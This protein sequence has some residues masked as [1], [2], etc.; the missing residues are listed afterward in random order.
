MS[1]WPH[2]TELAAKNVEAAEPRR[3]E[4]LLRVAARHHVLLG[5]EGRHVEIVDHVLGGHQETHRA[6]H[7]HVE[8]VQLA[9]ALGVLDVPHP[10]LADDVDLQR[11][12]VGRWDFQPVIEG[13]APDE[14]T[15]RDHQ[16]DGAPYEFDFPGLE[17][18]RRAVGVA[19]LTVLVQE[20]KHR[21][22]DHRQ[23]DQRE[24]DQRVE[25]RVRLPRHGGGTFGGKREVHGN[26]HKGRGKIRRGLRAGGG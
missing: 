10:L 25:K 2:A 6:T 13:R 12:G 23:H 9:L 14:E 11:I 19:A 4:P 20:V 24:Q 1:A 5:A 3:L 7:R 22:E 15:H 8:F 17:V 26:E 16:R 21:H 18:E